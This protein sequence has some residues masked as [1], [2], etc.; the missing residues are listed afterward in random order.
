MKQFYYSIVDK[1]AK[2]YGPMFPA[3][4]DL[5]AIRQYKNTMKGVPEDVQDSYKLMCLFEFDTEIG[6]LGFP[7]EQYEVQIEKKGDVE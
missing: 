2:E 5:I 3:K 1:D 4:N 6:Q 7:F